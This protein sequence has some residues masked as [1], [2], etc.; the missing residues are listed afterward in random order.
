MLIFKQFFFLISVGKVTHQ[1]KRF[2]ILG[3]F[4]YHRIDPAYRLLY[5]VEFTLTHVFF[6]KI[7][8]LILY[9]SFL[10]PTLCFTCF[11]AFLGTED[12]YIHINPPA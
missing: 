5:T 3:I 4:I 7:D 2:G 12:L 11:T 10:E 6:L 8:K 9:S 1:S